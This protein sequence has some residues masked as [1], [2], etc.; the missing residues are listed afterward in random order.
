[1]GMKDLNNLVGLEDDEDKSD[2][3]SDM[4]QN[5]PRTPV[6][7]K[8]GLDGDSDATEDSGDE[9]SHTSF[10]QPDVEAEFNRAVREEEQQERGQ[11]VNEVRQI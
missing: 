4:Q 8:N 7:S 2:L 1:M 9:K 10:G 5:S 11:V 3:D 6:S